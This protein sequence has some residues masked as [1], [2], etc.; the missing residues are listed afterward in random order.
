MTDTPDERV[1]GGEATDDTGTTDRPAIGAAGGGITGR[2]DDHVR[3]VTE[4]DIETGGS[5]FRDVQLVHEALPEIH[6]E[7]IASKKAPGRLPV[8][9]LLRVS[10]PSVVPVLAASGTE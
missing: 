7:E 9:A 2:K 3:I 10:L 5:G 4:E 8:R 1:D 6:R